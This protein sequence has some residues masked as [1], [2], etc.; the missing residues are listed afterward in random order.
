MSRPWLLSTL[1]PVALIAGSL[2]SSID[3]APASR[4]ARTERVSHSDR[5]ES[6]IRIRGR[7]VTAVNPGLLDG[8]GSRLVFKYHRLTIVDPVT[9]RRARNLIAGVNYDAIGLATFPAA[10][11]YPYVDQWEE[12]KALGFTWDAGDITIPSDG[13]FEITTTFSVDASLIGTKM[14]FSETFGADR[15][16]AAKFRVVR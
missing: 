12:G 8:G 9:G 6:G 15:D 13:L 2:S 16:R 1:L 7:R 5:A 4:K 3:P 14:T 11:M 10:G